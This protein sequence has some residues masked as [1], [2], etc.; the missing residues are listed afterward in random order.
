MVVCNRIFVG[1]AAI[2]FFDLDL[3][4]VNAVL[5]CFNMPLTELF[6]SL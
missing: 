5:K 3:K 4:E 2:V 1:E 6:P